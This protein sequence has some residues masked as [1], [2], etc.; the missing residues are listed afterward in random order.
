M[1]KLF[2]QSVELLSQLFAA[3]LFNPLNILLSNNLILLS[4]T[5]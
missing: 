3:M 4:I 2:I 5:F 1:R